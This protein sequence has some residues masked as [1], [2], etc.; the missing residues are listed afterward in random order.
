MSDLSQTS[1]TSPT[2]GA[3]GWGLTIQATRR[4]SRVGR[5]SAPGWGLTVKRILARKGAR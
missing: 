5:A 2:Y 4:P 1:P 3:H